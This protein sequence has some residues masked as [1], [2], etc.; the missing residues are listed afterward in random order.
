MVTNPPQVENLFINE[1][2]GGNRKR[3]MAR[4]EDKDKDRDIYFL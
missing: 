4:S 1:L 2:E 3:A